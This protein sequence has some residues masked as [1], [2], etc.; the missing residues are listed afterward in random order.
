[1]QG[2]ILESGFEGE[3]YLEVKGRMESSIGVEKAQNG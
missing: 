2:E 1:M 3:V